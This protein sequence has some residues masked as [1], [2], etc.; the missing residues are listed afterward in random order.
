MS[1]SAATALD[2]TTVGVVLA[3]AVVTYT[4]KAGGLWL[5]GRLE[6]TDRAETALEVLP[7]VIVVSL[8]AGELAEGGPAAWLGAAA[9]AVVVRK[10]ESLP[11]ALLAGI[12]TVVLVRGR[13]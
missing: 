4:T 7:G 11:L 1:S 5:V 13:I 9:V 12:G 8:V 2:P 3:M 6:L 10:T